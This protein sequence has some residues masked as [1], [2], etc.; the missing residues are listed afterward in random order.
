MGGF[1]ASFTA[2]ERTADGLPFSMIGEKG[3]PPGA[4]E[5]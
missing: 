3:A 2:F 4:R 1:N 5:K